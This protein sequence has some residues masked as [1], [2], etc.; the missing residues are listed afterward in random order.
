MNNCRKAERV[1]SWSAPTLV[2]RRLEIS[3]FGR[4]GGTTSR[5]DNCVFILLHTDLFSLGCLRWFAFRAASHSVKHNFVHCRQINKRRCCGKCV[6]RD[7]REGGG[8]A[9]ESPQKLALAFLFISAHL[10]GRSKQLWWRSYWQQLYYEL[11]HWQSLHNWINKTA[12]EIKYFLCCLRLTA[13]LWGIF[14]DVFLCKCVQRVAC[15][16][17]CVYAHVCGRCWL[18]RLL[19]ISRCDLVAESLTLKNIKKK[20]QQKKKPNTKPNKNMQTKKEIN[21]KMWAEKCGCISCIFLRCAH[22]GGAAKQ[23]KEISALCT[24][25]WGLSGPWL[26]G[27]LG[28]IVGVLIPS[29]LTDSDDTSARH[30]RLTAGLRSARWAF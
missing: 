21:K 27:F 11:Q 2:S 22:D 20:T 18:H 23:E 13:Y 17:V 15:I 24:T 16:C 10:K 8:G 29:Q 4:V 7:G 9:S 19:P 25:P 28:G 12:G 26:V 3:T 6:D 30:W 1:L 5:D 14:L